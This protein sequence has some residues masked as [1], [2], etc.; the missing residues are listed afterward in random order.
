MGK[1]GKVPTKKECYKLFESGSL[2]NKPKTWSSYEEVLADG[3]KGK[4]TMRSKAGMARKNVRYCVPLD[5]IPYEIEE[6]KKQGMKEKDI[7]FNETMPDEHIAIQGEIMK[8]ENGIYLL[9]STLKTQM[10]TALKEKPEHAFGLKANILLKEN[11]W[12]SSLADVEALLDLYPD[13]VIEFSAYE[14]AVG[15]LPGRNT[16]IWEVR[17]F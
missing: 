12:P 10:N 16:V 14:I 6:W 7:S 5:K 11:L 8:S 1:E 4:V 13:S 3:W 15:N 2:G 17:D 9:Y